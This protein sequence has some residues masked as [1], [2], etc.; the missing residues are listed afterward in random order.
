[1]KKSVGMSTLLVFLAI[2]LTL[3]ACAGSNNHE[4]AS[5]PSAPSSPPASSPA[6]SEPSST[7]S[8]SPSETQAVEP[9]E[10]K[11]YVDMNF[12]QVEDGADVP[13]VGTEGAGFKVVKVD[14]N[15]WAVSKNP[16][17]WAAIYLGTPD[18]TGTEIFLENFAIETKLMLPA[19]ND[20]IANDGGIPL[21][22]AAEGRYDAA[23][24]FTGTDL[25]YVNLWKA[26]NTDGGPIMTNNKAEFPDR[27]WVSDFK[28]EAGKEYV[29]TIIGTHRKDEDE[30][31][32]VRLRMYIDN[33]LVA[34]SEVPFW[35]GGFG[36][37]AWQS[38]IRY[39]YLKISDVPLVAPDGTSLATLE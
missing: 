16:Q 22:V 31:E 38:A 26:G 30:N 3:S 13:D 14:G 37:R 19:D 35:R 8:A 17:D 11:T 18:E 10:V 2:M 20:G 29:Y 27:G 12:D 39:D 7:P 28:L 4:P 23:L 33:Q 21:F 15:G 25:S 24:G 5:S 32:F 6:A 1:M 34:D 36:L 9:R